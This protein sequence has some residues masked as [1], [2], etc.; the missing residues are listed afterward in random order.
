MRL[1]KPFFFLLF[2][3]WTYALSA[4]INTIKFEHYTAKEGLSQSTVKC[5]QQDNL[6]FMWFGTIILSFLSS[7]FFQ[8]N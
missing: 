4:Q 1:L 2:F 5:I 8:L 7:R 6:G 3:G